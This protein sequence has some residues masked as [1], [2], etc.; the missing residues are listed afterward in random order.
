MDSITQEALQHFEA[1]LIRACLEKIRPD[2]KDED[3]MLRELYEDAI[4]A[5]RIRE[6]L[7]TTMKER[8]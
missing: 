2:V 3:P 1:S 7:E 6:P 4:K 8:S 5:G